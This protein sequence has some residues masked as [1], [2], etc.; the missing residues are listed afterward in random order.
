MYPADM[1]MM[2]IDFE[3]DM[4]VKPVK[5]AASLVNHAVGTKVSSIPVS[6]ITKI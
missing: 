4:P 5:P 6:V 2:M 1:D 3:P